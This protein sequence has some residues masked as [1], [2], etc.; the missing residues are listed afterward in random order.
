MIFG[1]FAVLL[2][3]YFLGKAMFGFDRSRSNPEINKVETDFGTHEFVVDTGAGA[4]KEIP[5]H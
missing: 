1:T 4:K 3:L 5:M 2:I